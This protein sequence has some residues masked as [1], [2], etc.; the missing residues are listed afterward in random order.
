MANKKSAKKRIKTS[1]KA[2]VRNT[3]R[4][5]EIKKNVKDLIREA[6]KEKKDVNEIKDMLRKLDK[7]V[8][9]AASRGVIHRNKASRIKSRMAQKINRTG[10]RGK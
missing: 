10:S 5:R 4:K 8:D 6:T 9:K 1:Q 7:G 3:R 2:R